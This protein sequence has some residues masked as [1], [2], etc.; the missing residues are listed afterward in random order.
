[1]PHPQN[2][3]AVSEMHASLQVV[4]G[5]VIGSKIIRRGEHSRSPEF[6][7]PILKLSS[8]GRAIEGCFFLTHISYCKTK[9]LGFPGGAVVKN[10]PANAGDMGS[11]PSLGRS[12]MPQSN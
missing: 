3:N 1:M 2:E 12:H 4:I 10:L 11:S 6:T 8:Q 5:A 7:L 9:D